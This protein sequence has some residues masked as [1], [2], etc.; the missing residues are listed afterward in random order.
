M[1]YNEFKEFLLKYI[2]EHLP[3]RLSQYELVCA[4]IG[5]HGEESITLQG[6]FLSA[7]LLNPADGYQAF[8]NNPS[9]LMAIMDAAVRFL[10]EAHTCDPD[11]MF[12]LEGKE[13][14]PY[15]VND[16]ERKGLKGLISRPF[17][18]LHICHA[19]FQLDRE[20]GRMR[21][22]PIIEPMLNH[23]HM[24]KDELL[25]KEREYL[26]KFSCVKPYNDGL[27]ILTT[28]EGHMGS[29]AMT[30]NK[31]LDV[32]SEYFAKGDFYLLPSSVFEMLVVP[33]SMLEGEGDPIEILKE[34]LKDENEA[35]GKDFILSETI[36]FY[37]SKRKKLEIADNML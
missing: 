37:S 30:N 29:I 36:Y 6:E 31:L 14:V 27:F 18:D 15:L 33:A 20:E 17:L 5:P 3:Y 12:N 24:T 23:L 34:V 19:I 21:V 26:E 2:K 11:E 9:D 8:E 10:S 28:K 32:C 22:C 4:N 13:I 1:N 7:P 25:K 16:V 35:I